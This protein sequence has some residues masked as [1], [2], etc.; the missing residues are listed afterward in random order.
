MRKTEKDFDCVRMK[1]EASL[2]IYEETR[3]MTKEEELAYWERKNEE[4]RRKYPGMR[5]PDQEKGTPETG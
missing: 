2:R 4:F 3:D 5:M 1:R